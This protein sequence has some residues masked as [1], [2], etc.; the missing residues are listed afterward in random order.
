MREPK[1]PSSVLAGR[2]GPMRD[3][4]DLPWYLRGTAA[5]LW[6]GGTLVAGCLI[7]GLLMFSDRH[8]R[9]ATLGASVSEATT[10]GSA[11]REGR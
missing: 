11:P 6:A 10:T 3:E 7:V 4:S 5:P 8:F 2:E 9:V 1:L